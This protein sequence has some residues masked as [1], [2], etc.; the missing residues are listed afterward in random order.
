M[1]DSGFRQGSCLSPSLFNVFIDMFVIN[2]HRV[3]VGCN[4]KSLFIGCLLYADDIILMA[5]S[6]SSLQKM[7]NC[8]SITSES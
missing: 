4:V 3:G 2:L 8:R 5:P 1:V 6:L 7:L